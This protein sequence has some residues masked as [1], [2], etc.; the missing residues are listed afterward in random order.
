MIT[1]IKGADLQQFMSKAGSKSFAAALAGQ[2]IPGPV[3]TYGSAKSEL[4]CLV[5]STGFLEIAAN[6]KSAVQILGAK[7]G[8]PLTL[9]LL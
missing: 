7:R 8:Q 6:Q 5:G 4:F 3:P 9:Q 1:N 2:S